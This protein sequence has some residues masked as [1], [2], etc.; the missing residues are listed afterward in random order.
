[1]ADCLKRLIHFGFLP[2][3][4]FCLLSLSIQQLDRALVLLLEQPYLVKQLNGWR[5]TK[6]YLFL[7]GIKLADDIERILDFGVKELVV[8]DEL[9]PFHRD[10][11]DTSPMVFDV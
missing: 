2:F 5:H 9:H 1:V 3:D 8:I 6:K 4:E 10:F 7:Q 11:I